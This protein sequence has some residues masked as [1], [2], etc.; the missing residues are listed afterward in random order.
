V[1]LERWNVERYKAGYLTER[2]KASYD[3]VIAR[4]QLAWDRKME[5][6]RDPSTLSVRYI[7][8]AL[9]D[10]HIAAARKYAPT[11]YSG[12]VLLFRAGKQVNGSADELWWKSLLRGAVTACEMPGITRHQFFVEP[13]VSQ[14]AKKLSSELK[15][16]QQTGP[17]RRPQ[18]QRAASA[19]E[20]TEWM[21]NAAS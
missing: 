4:A 9:A 2:L 11:P 15:V 21:F 5:A 7:L 12:N 19:E 3:R 13:A 14:V 17:A 6:R 8:H 18:G 20:R 10:E 16:A 1:E